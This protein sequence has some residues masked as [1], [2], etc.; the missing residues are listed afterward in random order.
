MEFRRESEA[1]VRCHAYARHLPHGYGDD[2]RVEH[3]S[4]WSTAPIFS[5]LAS[6]CR[7][8]F[9]G[10]VFMQTAVISQKG[11]PFSYAR[12]STSAGGIS[13]YAAKV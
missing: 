6:C 2:S 1:S 9:R 8:R 7:I 13:Y 4:L 12:F 11:V 5:F 10:T 3:S